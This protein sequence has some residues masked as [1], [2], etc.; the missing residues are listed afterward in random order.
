MSMQAVEEF[1]KRM[2]EDP[3]LQPR[4]AEAYSRGP[5]ALVALGHELGYDFTEAEV[6]QAIAEASSGELSDVE[7]ELASA[8]GGNGMTGTGGGNL[9]N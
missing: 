7:L 9:S 3:S 6:T 5:A 2:N 4:I 8:G 1:R